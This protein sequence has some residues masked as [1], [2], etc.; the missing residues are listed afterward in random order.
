MI[1][2]IKGWKKP[3][4]HPMIAVDNIIVKGNKILLLRRNIYPFKGKL[5]Y[6]AGMVEYGERIEEAAIRETKEETGLKI[7]L[8]EILGVYSDPERDPRFHT[9][10][11]VF[12]AEPTGG[13]L[14]SS[15]EGD[16]DWCDINK[17][18]FTDLGF[19]HAKILKDYI[20]WKKKKGTF[21]STR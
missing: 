20:K 21:W 12:I 10:T 4:K 7:K 11:V 6:P 15:F 8:K 16:A 17:I 1:M 2:K 14:K 13:K 3:V 18:N 5:V 19:D 9:A